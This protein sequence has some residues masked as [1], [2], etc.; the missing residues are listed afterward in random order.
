MAFH[1]CE[2]PSAGSAQ[3]GAGKS[4]CSAA[5]DTE[6]NTSTARCVQELTARIIGYISQLITHLNAANVAAASGNIWGIIVR[7]R[8]ARES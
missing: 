1:K 3:P 8:K 2:A 6:S 5:G 7:L 4:L